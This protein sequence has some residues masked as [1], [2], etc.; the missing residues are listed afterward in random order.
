[1]SPK[2]S[3]GL[4]IIERFSNFQVHAYT[5]GKL[6]CSSKNSIFRIDDL[7]RPDPVEI[8]RIPWR[9]VQHLSNIRFLDRALKHAILQVHSTRQGGFLVATGHSWWRLDKTGNVRPVGSFSATRPMNRGI[10]ESKTGWTYV[11]EYIPNP[12][13]GPIRIF[14]SGDLESFETAWRFEAGTIRHVHAVI[15][16]PDAHNRI[17]IL[18][19]D[20]DQESHVYYTD[21]DFSTVKLFLSE[22]QVTR[23]TDLISRGDDLYWGMDSPLK[24]SFIIRASRQTARYDKLLELPGPAYYIGQNDGGGIYV[25]TTVEPGPAVK[26]HFGRIF[27]SDKSGVWR[28]IVRCK[29]DPFPQYGIF[30]FPKGIL[31]ENFIVY[32]QRAL[33][34]YEGYMTIATDPALPRVGSEGAG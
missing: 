22:G 13:R 21:D 15:T 20:E 26:D 28:E 12:N 1:M 14:R 32:S 10:C 19:G 2:S 9:G 31:P 6:I 24:T 3:C 29:K 18:T 25:G 17:W 8:G 33:L 5:A 7:S 23:A 4:E 27:G 34:P 16:D 11:A 30:Y